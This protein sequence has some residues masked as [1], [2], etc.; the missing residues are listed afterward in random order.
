MSSMSSTPSA[1]SK[2]SS[3]RTRDGRRRG[4]GERHLGVEPG[5]V[6]GL[7]HALFSYVRHCR[8]VSSTTPSRRP[9]RGDRSG[10]PQAPRP[11]SSRSE[12]GRAAARTR[13]R[14]QLEAP[15]APR[16]PAPRRARAAR[17]SSVVVVDSRRRTA[18]AA[19]SRCRRPRRRRSAR[20]SSTRVEDAASASARS[21]L[22]LVRRR[23]VAAEVARRPGRRSRRGTTPTSSTP[24]GDRAGDELASSRRRRRRPR[25]SR[26]A[27][28]RSVARRAGEREPRLLVAVESTPTGT[29]GSR[30]RPPRTA[31][32]GWP[33]RGSRRWRRRGCA[34]APALARQRACAATTRRRARRPSRRRSRRRRPSRAAMNARSREDLAQPGRR[35]R[36]ATSS[37]VVFEP[38]SMQAQRMAVAHHIRP[39]S[40]AARPSSSATCASA[41][42][43]LRGGPRASTSRSRR[44][45]VFGL[46]GPNGA[47]KT[48]TVE[49]LEGYRTRDER[50]RLGARAT[51]P[52][53]ARA[54]CASASASSCRAPGMYRHITVREAVAHWARLYPRPR[55]VDEVHRARRA[56]RRRRTRYA[57]TLSRR[58]AAA[59]GLRARAGRRPGADLPR[60]ADDRLRPGGAP[61]GVGRRP[62]ARRTSARPSC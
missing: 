39:V 37:R 28:R 47:G 8:E 32:R 61:R 51:T 27:A 33:R 52:S 55:D 18:A 16:R 53:S 60:R 40:A 7:G 14:V 31:R 29:P 49:I 19:T 6:T 4:L 21:A 43:T 45:E 38:M 24:P 15:R 11:P 26:R 30:V 36:S 42:A 23:R 59:P 2:S 46:L 3:A 44:G 1:C 9:P 25:R 35:S 20:G 10:S 22:E 17:R 56:A 62:L 54:S 58:P 5:I 12:P 48:T 57:R 34:A 41:T 50:H 13:S